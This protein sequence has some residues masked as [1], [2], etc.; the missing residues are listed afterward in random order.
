MSSLNSVYKQMTEILSK[1]ENRAPEFEANRLI[2]FVLGN[3]RLMLGRDFETDSRQE[4]K[5]ISLCE[6]RR[7]GY[8]LQYILGS[9]RFFDLDLSVGE[10]VL[11]PRGDTEDVCSAAFEFLKDIPYPN[12][13][14][15]CSGT[16]AIALATKRFFPQSTVVAVEK[17][18][19][20][21][22]YLKKNI[23]K[24][25]LAVHPIL[26][27]VFQFDYVCDDESFDMIISNPPYI[28]PKLEGKLQKE[29]SFEPGSALFADNYGLRFYKF[30]SKD[31]FHALKPGGYLVFEH[32]YDQAKD[33]ENLILRDDY[34]IVKRITD[35]GGNPRGIIAQKL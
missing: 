15:L 32:G 14:D 12:V 7:E 26:S 8:P 30:I 25:G 21:F 19:E 1:N 34:K 27:D 33:V 4:E 13:L 10:G 29:V 3:S 35:T 24:T 31:Y 20:A 28:D 17:F 6:K 16:G 11:I 5:L 23:E 2:E 18:P 9:W 22:E